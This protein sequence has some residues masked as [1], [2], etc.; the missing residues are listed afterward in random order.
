MDNR[1]GKNIAFS[2]VE[3]GGILV[4]QF[5]S[6]VLLSK[7]LPREQLGMLAVMSGAFAF[8]QFANV[9]L[10][11]ILIRDFHEHKERIHDSLSQ[12]FSFNMYKSL[13]LA[14]IALG[15][16]S[17]YYYSTGSSAFLLAALSLISVLVMDIWV[18]PLILYSTTVFEQKL[19]T[20]ISFV[21]WGLNLLGLLLLIKWPDIKVVLG[22]D[23]V[24][25]LTTIGCWKMASRK[26]LNLKINFVKIN[27]SFVRET[28]V[29][30]AFYVH[31]LGVSSAIIYK[32]DGFIL[33]YF[34]PLAVIGKY[35]IALTLANVASVIPSVLVA[36]NNVALSHCHDLSESKRITARFLRFSILIGLV[37]FIGF[38]VLG[39]P[40]LYVVAPSDQNE[41]YHYLL[42]IVGGLLL[43]KMIVAPLVAFINMKGDVKSLL[44]KVQLPILIIALLN[45]CL[46][47]Y[48]LGAR[49]A[50]I[51]NLLNGFIW[52]LLILKEVKKYQFEFSELGTFK[53]DFL[54]MKN[55]MKQF[56]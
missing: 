20:K 46:F 55:F 21:R 12:F 43:V 1:L 32:A 39:I 42:F 24:V 54:L 2:F 10:E 30:Y 23:I 18:S 38:A 29:G 3:K 11:N 41:I 16:G 27:W 40:Y 22:K 33:Y 44:L 6:S 36:Q 50:A 17:F 56:I 15:I 19:V 45:Y 51:S 31:L 4:S 9:S 48:F 53:E 14:T 8:L 49:G 37:S 28:F 47:S 7:Y 35:N 5:I 34:A 25:F 52:F 26:T 13:F